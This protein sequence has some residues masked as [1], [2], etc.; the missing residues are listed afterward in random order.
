MF[1]LI[2]AVVFDMLSKV[3]NRLKDE[4]QLLPRNL[5]QQYLKYDLIR[6]NANRYQRAVFRGENLVY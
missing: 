3:I 6:S 2:L 4:Y 5:S 1:R